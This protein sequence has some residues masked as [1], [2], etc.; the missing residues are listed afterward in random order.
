MQFSD[1]S[2]LTGLVEEMD[3]LCASNATSFP[4]K[5]KARLANR[6]NYKVVVD[7]IGS[8][9]RWQYDDRNNTTLPIL[10]TDLVDAQQ[11]YELPADMLRLQAVE[12]KDNDGNWHRLLPIDQRDLDS[13]SDFNTTD[14][15]PQYYDV[16]GSSL[17]LE[18][19]PAAADV[20]TTAGLK[21]YVSREINH[22]LSTDTTQEPGFAEAFHPIISYGASYDF[23]VANGPQERADKIRLELEQLR[24]ELRDFYG[25]QNEEEK[26][27]FRPAA[28]LRQSNFT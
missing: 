2:N 16:R 18:P 3:F 20:T 13:I 4:L 10:T 25:D 8:Q 27:R 12:F 22:F 23:L 11:D 5:D 15:T 7:I 9:N 21:L 24:Q 19:A 1:T 26:T 17:F 28:S 14:G 6:W